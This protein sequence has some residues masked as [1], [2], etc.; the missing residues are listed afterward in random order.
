MARGQDG[1]NRPGHV[2]QLAKLVATRPAR[3]ARTDG[4]RCQVH[5]KS[6]RSIRKFAGC[7][8]CRNW[9][10]RCHGFVTLRSNTQAWADMPWHH[11]SRS[12]DSTAHAETSRTAALRTANPSTYAYAGFESSCHEHR[13]EKRA[14]CTMARL[15]SSCAGTRKQREALKERQKAR[16]QAQKQ[17]KYRFEL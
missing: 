1:A 2:V 13:R 3:P 4:H 10:A 8:L 14:S 12:V 17:S 5:L 9:V 16:A 15:S 11:R 6:G 7:E